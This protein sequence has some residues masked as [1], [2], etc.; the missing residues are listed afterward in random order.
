[1]PTASAVGGPPRSEQSPEG[2]APRRDDLV[3]GDRSTNKTA[4]TVGP[5]HLH[6][7]RAPHS[8]IV[9]PP[10]SHYRQARRRD[11]VGTCAVLN[12]RT[13]AEPEVGFVALGGVATAM[14]RRAGNQRPPRRLDSVSID[15]RGVEARAVSPP[16]RRRSVRSVGPASA[17]GRA[18]RGLDLTGARQLDGEPGSVGDIPRGRMTSM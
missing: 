7:H 13:L 9:N 14:R 1:M 18:D 4:W 10:A 3:V 17:V 6:H 2:V 5:E 15:R 11:G 8:D 12:L 16:G